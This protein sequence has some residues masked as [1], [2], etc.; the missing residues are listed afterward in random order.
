ML[1]RKLGLAVAAILC[2]GL[3]TSCI[4][5]N[6]NRSGGDTENGIDYTNYKGGE[7]SIKVN[8]ESSKNVV[9]F[10]G[11]PAKGTLISGARG[12]SVTTGLKLDKKLFS[13]SEDFVLYVF[14]EE[15]YLK[16]KNDYDTLKTM[17]F[18]L[19]YAYYNADSASN[20][21][22]VYT[23]SA[24]AGGEAY[25][26][27]NNPTNYN[28]EMRQ[29]GLYGDSL[30][31]AG[32]NTLQTKINVAYG[33]YYIYPVFRKFHKKT[34]EIVSCFPK[35]T[36]GDPVVR[37]FGLHEEGKKSAE[38]NVRDWFD[39]NCFKDYSTPAAAY[40]TITNANESGVCL[41]KGA[42]SEAEVTSTG[43]KIINTGDNYLV[44]EIPMG[45]IGTKTFSSTALV[46]GWR[47]GAP[48][49]Y[50]NEGY[51][52]VEEL[53]VEAGKMYYLDV[54]GTTYKPVVE[55][56]RVNGEIKTDTVEVDFDVTK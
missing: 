10:K 2:V 17:P 1:K 35:T 34:G 52:L 9:C 16:Y 47:V 21:N 31:F 36:D 5:I 46:S 33:D 50:F 24:N 18:A 49:A 19:I 53:T 14:T 29:N 23:I 12:G 27:I 22:L 13:T 51:G 25:I 40:V 7:Y 55:W 11:V 28:V 56:R 6:D 4:N 3:M 15:D 42:D 39:P 20:D 45:A 8:N 26:I 48:V 37:F 38:F 32:N 44:F 54:K 30:A 43:G 41:Y